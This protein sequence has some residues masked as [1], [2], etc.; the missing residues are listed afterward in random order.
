MEKGKQFRTIL[1]FGAPGSGKGT[2]GRILG[3]LP[4]FY[5]LSCG[6]VFRALNHRSELGQVFLEYSSQGKLVPDEFTIRLWL[7]RP[8]W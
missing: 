8:R 7:E 3:D 2:Q 4:G 5:H 6:D 1:M